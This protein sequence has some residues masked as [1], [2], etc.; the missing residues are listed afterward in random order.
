MFK[1]HLQNNKLLTI[2][3]YLVHGFYIGVMNL[4][5]CCAALS[6]CP[7]YLLLPRLTHWARSRFKLPPATRRKGCRVLKQGTSSPGEGRKFWAGYHLIP[8]SETH[9]EAEGWLEEWPCS[10]RLLR[11]Q[12]S[13]SGACSFS[14]LSPFHFLFFYPSFFSFS[15]TKNRKG[16]KGNRKKMKGA[17][18]VNS[19]RWEFSDVE[20]TR[21]ALP[22]A[23][24]CWGV[25]GRA[26]E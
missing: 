3:I 5:C 1:T 4:L 18:R 19:G 12:P 25:A 8:I 2:Y 14:F 17:S 11:S 9:Q 22:T 7:V 21:G 13:E 10:A 26:A 23:G 15:F 20:Q 16:L 24:D 6:S